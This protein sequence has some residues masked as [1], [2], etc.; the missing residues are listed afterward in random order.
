MSNK[1]SEVDLEIQR[2]GDERDR[3]RYIDSEPRGEQEECDG[4]KVREKG[5]NAG[6]GQGKGRNSETW[7]RPR[8]RGP[9]MWREG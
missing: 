7:R 5:R 4:Q 2:N 1:E 3:G 8:E 9:G 6:G